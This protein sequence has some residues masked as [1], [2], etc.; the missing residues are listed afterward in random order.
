MRCYLNCVSGP[1]P[2]E[3]PDGTVVVAGVSVSGDEVMVWPVF[4][5]PMAGSRL[6]DSLDGHWV[7]RF[8]NGVWVYDLDPSNIF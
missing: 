5:D 6:F 1:V 3:V 8:V 4:Q 2:V 7:K